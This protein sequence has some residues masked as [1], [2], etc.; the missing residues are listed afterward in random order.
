MSQENPFRLF[1]THTWEESEDYVRFFD[2]ISEIESFFY[3]NLS[4]PDKFPGSSIESIQSEFNRQ[5]KPSELVVVLSSAYVKDA[6]LVQYQ[7]D[8]ARALAKPVIAV[9]PF[10]PEPMLK[11]LKDRAEQVVPWYNR[12]IVDA[13][14]HHGRGE[15]TSPDF[16]P[17]K[18]Q[19]ASI[20][21][22][23]LWCQY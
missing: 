6:N 1:I 21:S 20:T 18:P 5:M 14:L 19:H 11:P 16:Q 23:V 3:T 7:L 12:A 2:Y 4:E 17:L 10:G 13:I 22:D 9:E 8:L 15:N